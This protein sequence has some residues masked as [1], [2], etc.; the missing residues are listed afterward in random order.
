MWQVVMHLHA[1]WTDGA[2]ARGMQKRAPHHSRRWE[3]LSMLS[4]GSSRWFTHMMSACTCSAS[5]PSLPEPVCG[6]QRLFTAICTCWAICPEW[7]GTSSQLAAAAAHRP[8]LVCGLQKLGELSEKCRFREQTTRHMP[9][10]SIHPAS[11]FALGNRCWETQRR[12]YFVDTRIA[13]LSNRPVRFAD[14]GYASKVV[15][16]T[17]GELHLAATLYDCVCV[18]KGFRWVQVILFCGKNLF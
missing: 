12:W 14:Y 5:S 8:E 6:S 2:K 15:C 11:E 1:F 7:T 16:A 4:C 18:Y 13:L 3:H 10:L 17:T 9:L